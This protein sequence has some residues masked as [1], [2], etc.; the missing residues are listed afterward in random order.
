MTCPRHNPARVEDPESNYQFPPSLLGVAAQGLV[1]AG[2]RILEAGHLSE[3][4]F[5]VVSGAIL[6]IGPSHQVVDVLGSGEWTGVAAAGV[7]AHNIFRGNGLHIEVACR[8]Q[9][10]SP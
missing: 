7:D 5:G 6:L 8:S 9:K 2:R 4:C 3:I 10:L 1:P